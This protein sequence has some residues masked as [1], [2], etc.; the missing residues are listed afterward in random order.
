MLIKVYG[1]F[2]RPDFVYWGTKGPGG[3]G[4]LEGTARIEKTDLTVDNWKQTGI[5]ILY[6]DRDLLYVGKAARN[7]L[8]ARLRHHL[9]DQLAG[10]WNRFSWYGVRPVD[11][12]TGALKEIDPSLLHAQYVLPEVEAILISA[13]EP[14]LNKQRVQLGAD[15]LILEQPIPEGEETPLDQR[16]Y[17]KVKALEQ[18]IADIEKRL[19]P[20]EQPVKRRGR[21]KKAES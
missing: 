7:D 19:K 12:N 17:A 9:T 20:I 16:T 11:K 13:T 15:V 3:G 10:R 5:Y 14:R 18:L 6:Q 1:E 4:R 8:G 2:W 21:K